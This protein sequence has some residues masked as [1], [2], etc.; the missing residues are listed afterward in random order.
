M[1]CKIAEC[2]LRDLSATV[3]HAGDM[4]SNLYSRRELFWARVKVRALIA[5]LL[6]QIR[7]GRPL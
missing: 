1:R 5:K 4:A 2:D 3:V 6:K 7:E